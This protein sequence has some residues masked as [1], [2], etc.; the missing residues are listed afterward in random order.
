LPL[1]KRCFSHVCVVGARCIVPLLCD[2]S[3]EFALLS[4]L[5][6]TIM[7]S[8]TVGIAAQEDGGAAN[9]VQV[10]A[11][12]GLAL[13]GD[14]YALPGDG[15]AVLLLHQLYTTRVSWNPVIPSLLA[16]GYRVLNVDL[17]G[18]GGT[19]G[20]I[21]WSQAQVDTRTWVQWLRAQPGVTNVFIMGS[22]M[23][24]NL[25]LVGCAQTVCSGAVAI[26]PGRLVYGVYTEDAVASGIPALLV[27]AERDP[28]PR[29]SV[30]YLQELEG[31]NV[32]VIAY[33]GRDH[34]ML[35]FGTQADLIAQI[36]AWMSAR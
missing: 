8:I 36:I 14:Y 19:R 34:G 29:R 22:S 4:T 25:A 12:D 2:R 13:S 27:Y 21:N 7:L 1:L 11:S 31:A 18:Y 35:L 15:P 3:A 5:V 9:A 6:I 33:S 16:S 10:E 24:S 20:K 26:S 28:Y 32:E 30:P 17:R 23:G